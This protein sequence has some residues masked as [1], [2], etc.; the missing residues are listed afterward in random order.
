MPRLKPFS[1]LTILLFS[2]LTTAARAEEDWST[3]RHQLLPEQ[4]HQ[5]VLHDQMCQIW[6]RKNEISSVSRRD[7]INLNEYWVPKESVRIIRSLFSEE[8]LKLFTT[9]EGYIR[10]LVPDFGDEHVI[11]NFFRS[12]RDKMGDVKRRWLAYRL[13]GHASY[14]AWAE[15]FDPEKQTPLILKIEIPEGEDKKTKDYSF[16]GEE[17]G[18]Q[19]LNTQK[20]LEQLKQDQPFLDLKYFPEPLA[21]TYRGNNFSYSFSVREM[22]DP[23]IYNQENLRLLPL[24]GVL[25]SMLPAQFARQRKTREYDWL[26]QYAFQIGKYLGYLN[27]V[28]GVWPIMH[29]QN[30]AA[31]VDMKEGVLPDFVFKDLADT[32]VHPLVWALKGYST[33]IPKKNTP[34]LI[35]MDRVEGEPA[36]NDPVVLY[37]KYISQAI[38]GT[39]DGINWTTQG[40][41][42]FFLGILDGA[43]LNISDLP[44]ETQVLLKQ[45][46]TDEYSKDLVIKHGS[47][48]FSETYADFYA[49][50]R[51]IYKRVM[52][53]MLLQRL[54]QDPNDLL[55]DQA[56]LAKIFAAKVKKGQV[57]WR[58]PRDASKYPLLKRD[59]LRY[60][61]SMQGIVAYNSVT[62]DPLGL[63]IE[64]TDCEGL[65]KMDD[66]LK[67]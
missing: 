63:A 20:I 41:R 10:I 53:K 60:L 23:K 51:D 9:S 30:A 58:L 13:Q 37:G 65:L 19:A 54:Q 61:Q 57:Q 4:W 39:Q 33:S 56:Q 18:V 59:R 14:M 49:I 7:I 43:G 29:T 50:F 15:D 6:D 21:V 27:F 38:T 44:M 66:D 3:K 2:V 8:A 16:N 36:Y 42:G 35:S 52:H 46:K 5:Y 28:A 55:E 12:I 48:E 31:V 25:G 24:H 62:M 22:P 1:F 47:Q 45:F 17:L 64:Y 32:L 34:L 67:P 11:H 40:L 26:N